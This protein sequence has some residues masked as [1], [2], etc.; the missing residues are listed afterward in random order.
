MIKVYED[1]DTVSIQLP[2]EYGTIDLSMEEAAEL[3]NALS[4]VAK[5]RTAAETIRW[6][7]SQAKAIEI[8]RN[9]AMNLTSLADAAEGTKS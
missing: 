5:L 8:L 9:A 2:H 1:A 7:A 6:R 3:L 4:M